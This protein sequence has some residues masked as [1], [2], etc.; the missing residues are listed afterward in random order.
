V[1]IQPLADIHIEMTP[2]D[3]PAVGDVVVLAG[4]IG[5]GVGGVRW[6]KRQFAGR[7]TVYVAGNHTYYGHVFP[8]TI[9]DLRA[10]AEGSDVH[11]LENDELILDGVRFLGATLWTDFCLEGV[12][13]Q[14]VAMV[15]AKR[16]MN[17][18]RLIRKA[19]GELLQPRD[20]VC[21]HN[22]SVGWLRQKLAEP[23][24][25]ST[26]VVTHHAPCVMSSPREYR[27]N[28]LTPAFASNLETLI[29]EFSPD[30]WIS[31]HTHYSCDYQIGATR[32]VSNQRGYS[33]R[34]ATGFDAAL[35]IQV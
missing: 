22:E 10:E 14:Q 28:G 35:T 16:G 33:D 5:I 3:I 18:F 29:L 31:G 4:D 21:A 9:A 6:A 15:A 23:H 7:P 26:V 20:M 19:S 8:E 24:E 17:D 2:C 13:H 30:L 11:I 27:F 12:A 25:G 34:E 32:M 1:K